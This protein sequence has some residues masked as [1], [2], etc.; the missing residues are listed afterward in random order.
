MKRTQ[1]SQSKGDQ[2]ARGP[3]YVLL[4]LMAALLLTI[5]LILAWNACER[6]DLE[7]DRPTNAAQSISCTT[8]LGPA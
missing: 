7:T 4:V 5:A 1:D 8:P 2:P 6:F 3:F